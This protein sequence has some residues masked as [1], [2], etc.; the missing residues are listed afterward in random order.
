MYKYLLILLLI[1]TQLF[2]SETIKLKA[3]QK[4]GYVSVKLLIKS[5][6]IGEKEAKKRNVA[7]KFITSIHAYVGNRTVYYIATSQ[8]LT[9]HPF[10]KFKYK[11]KD[12]EDILNISFTNNEGHATTKKVKIKN[13]PTKNRSLDAI[14]KNSNTRNSNTVK[15]K[16]WK[17]RN[18]EQATKELYGSDDIIKGDF[19]IKMPNIYVNYGSI[20][21]SIT[22]ELELESLAVFTN[23]NPYAA[24]AIFLIP[25][26]EKVDYSFRFRVEQP[27]EIVVIGKG[28]DGKLYKAEPETGECTSFVNPYKKLFCKNKELANLREKVLDY[29]LYI[30]DD[31]DLMASRKVLLEQPSWTKS[32]A[33]RC[34]SADAS[35]V[36]KHYEDR[37]SLLKQTYENPAQNWS[38]PKSTNLKGQAGLDELVK[39]GFIRKVT[40]S[41]MNR[42]IERKLST[43]A[44]EKQKQFTNYINAIS[45]SQAE[46]FKEYVKNG[47]V[48]LKKTTLPEELYG[49]SSATFFLEDNVQYPEGRLGNSVLY[50]FD[51]MT[52][53]GL[54]CVRSFPK[55]E[56]RKVDFLTKYT[57]VNSKPGST[58]SNFTPK[59]INKNFF[60]DITFK[61]KSVSKL[62]FNKKLSLLAVGYESGK[63]DLFDGVE[64]KLRHHFNSFSKRA[65][66][67]NFSDSGKY[68][69]VSGYFENSTK[70]YNTKT[71]KLL[72]KIPNTRG[73][74]S[75]VLNDQFLIMADT[76][77]L[78][79]L[80]LKMEALQF[81]EYKCAGVINSIS[82]S[83]DGSLLA[84]GSTSRVQLF[85]VN[86][87]KNW[88]DLRL[89]STSTGYS[90]NDWIVNS[91]FS[92]DDTELT[93][94]YRFGQI[95]VL[96][97]Y[98]LEKKDSID[99]K[100]DAIRGVVFS[101]DRKASIVV[102]VEGSRDSKRSYNVEVIDI[103]KRDSEV[104]PILRTNYP[105]ISSWADINNQE[106]VFIE[107]NNYKLLYRL[108]KAKKYDADGV[109]GEIFG[110][111]LEVPNFYKSFAIAYDNGT[112]YAYGYSYGAATQDKA[113]EEA[114]KDC[115][116]SR[117]R[118]KA[119]ELS[120]NRKNS[121]V[122]KN[123]KNQCK[124]YARG[125]EY[126]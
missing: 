29:Y 2:A 116:N 43:Y 60:K 7:P 47:Y 94:V 121:R 55:R 102:G 69:S 115:R 16:I 61:K 28:R 27:K 75:F 81:K 6:M 59:E 5:S 39:N 11:Y 67:L 112:N 40:D 90:S 124:V 36:K 64:S 20:P 9:Q 49:K 122:R 21:I 108:S 123:G 58:P 84:V 50:E 57:D 3:K 31:P 78:K 53:N 66:I 104:S 107:H 72:T 52:C 105:T 22:S 62:A 56:W 70:V 101:S 111:Y 126:R 8:Y 23:G 14:P 25:K 38:M 79:I 68:L 15:N 96:N 44:K 98:N 97:I 12:K 95:D 86:K 37:L 73:P 74:S 110:K 82:L 34:P 83:H 4:N 10:V 99:I 26:G 80:N 89:L 113:D 88:I 85:S 119:K 33:I 118:K 30:K 63:V 87:T 19:T 24:V 120:K 13:I 114:L 76:S 18:V 100:T 93:V 42:W 1:S 17:A 45:S 51:T 46:L 117:M 125:D 32:L 41:D 91:Y 106:F 54:S 92:V 103:S 109:F 48:I 77:A 65:N 35:C 71:G